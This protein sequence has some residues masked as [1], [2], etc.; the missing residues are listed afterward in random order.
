MSTSKV[1]KDYKKGEFEIMPFN[2]TVFV[3]VAKTVTEAVEIWNSTYTPEIPED[4]L[5][6][7]VDGCMIYNVDEEGYPCWCLLFEE[8]VDDVVIV[9]EC[10]HLLMDIADS[11]GASWSKSS[12]EWYAYA[13]Q[14][15]FNKVKN[16]C[17]Q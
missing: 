12:D 16:I 11:K 2:V 13:L 4:L 6:E 15:I 14:D 5:K 1:K 8:G 9:H 3:L 10:F 17:Q 7:N